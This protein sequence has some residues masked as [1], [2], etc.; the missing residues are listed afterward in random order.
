MS[1]IIY[2]NR[3]NVFMY[4]TVSDCPHHYKIFRFTYRCAIY[5][6]FQ[7]NSLVFYRRRSGTNI[8]TFFFRIFPCLNELGKSIR[9]F[10]LKYISESLHN[11]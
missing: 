9:E 5:R 10:K 11:I 3:L 8:F 4:I 6:I 1:T 2:H 7:N